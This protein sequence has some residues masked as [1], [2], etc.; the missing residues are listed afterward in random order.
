[1]RMKRMTEDFPLKWLICIPSISAVQGNVFETLHD[2]YRTA[3]K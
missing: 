1:M 2:F 3:I